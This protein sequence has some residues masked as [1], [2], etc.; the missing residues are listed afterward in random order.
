MKLTDTMQR[1]I[2]VA[3]TLLLLP[4]CTLTMAQHRVGIPG[5]SHPCDLRAERSGQWSGIGDRTGMGVSPSGI[6]TH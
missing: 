3:L 6:A 4:L 2:A 5:W 1:S